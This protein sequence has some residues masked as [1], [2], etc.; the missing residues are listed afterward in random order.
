MILG[1][2]GQDATVLSTPTRP[3]NAAVGGRH[4]VPEIHPTKPIPISERLTAGFWT[5]VDR[6]DADQ[7][8]LWLGKRQ[9]DGYGRYCG[10]VAH[11]VAYTISR[12]PIAN[13][14][15]IDHVCGRRECV[16]PT[17]LEAVTR[18]ENTERARIAKRPRHGAYRTR[19]QPSRHRGRRDRGLCAQCT[20]PS[21]TYRCDRCNAYL[22]AWRAA[23]KDSR[24]HTGG[25]ER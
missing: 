5:R 25:S 20:V 9:I 16:N 24:P 19:K 7:C 15:T 6:R 21:T 13:G 23:K 12:G 8:W 2:N 17:H 3:I 10:Y 4:T 18:S 1:Y 22:R 11:R 14:L